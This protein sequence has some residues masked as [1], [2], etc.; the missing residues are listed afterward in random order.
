MPMTANNK[1]NEITNAMLKSVV[2]IWQAPML[3]ETRPNQ[4]LKCGLVPQKEGPAGLFWFFRLTESEYISD[5]C[6]GALGVEGA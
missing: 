1:E 4:R 2:H 3:A 6:A 5:K